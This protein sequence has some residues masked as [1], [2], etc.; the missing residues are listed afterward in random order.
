[1]AKVLTTAIQNQYNQQKIKTRFILKINNVD[2]SDYL[3]TWTL[4]TSK[5]FGSSQAT[6]VLHNNSEIFSEGGSSNIKVGDV[7]AFSEFFQEDST[8]F[9]K[10]YGMISQRSIKKT[11]SERSITLVCL[12]YISTLQYLDIDLECEGDK[13]LIE[14]ETLTPNYLPYPNDSLAHIFNFANNAIAQN[15]TPII[16]IKNKNT[17]VEDPQY[18][19]FEIMYEDGQLKL[20]YPLNALHN[21]DVICS[22]YYFYVKGLYAEDIIES[23]LTLPDGYGKYLFNEATA[24]DVI[25]NHLIDSFQ[26]VENTTTD[27]MS[28]NYTPSEITVE[29]YLVG[30]INSSAT[31][32]TV[33][34]A[35][36]L[37]DSG[38]G[39]VAGDIFTWS[40]K[41]GNILQ[42]IPPTGTYSLSNHKATS[43]VT[44]TY[45]FPRGQVWY[46]KYSN[47]QTD[48]VSGDFT[49][50]GANFVYLDKRFGRI[51]LDTAIVTDSVVTCNSNYSF[52]TLQASGIELSTMSFRSREVENRFA[53]LKK[54]KDYLAPN[55]MIL[56]RG[57]E[58]IWSMYMSQKTREDYT[59]QLET[60]L[61]YLEDEDLYTRVV[62]YGKNKNPTNLMF[63]DGISFGSTGE[64]YKS[65]ASNSDIV[66]S[67]EEGDFWVY[68]SP[69]SGIGKIL[70]ETMMPTVYLNDVAIDN[71][72]HIIAGQ[73]VAIE[74]TTK[75][76]TT[77]S[78][79]GK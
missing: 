22:K 2:Y 51:I 17:D 42:G 60:S 50:P 45:T 36:G 65:I 72:S 28:P 6:F 25:D 21:Y 49:I 32:L 35:S 56:T 55:Y 76:D 30:D 10:F 27:T 5:E 79:G 15:P 11:S 75:T 64:T 4:Q 66:I 24:Q 78:G 48:L 47:L 16:V 38:E 7:V 29:T 1:M 63:G 57:D 43:L 69:I 26:N 14:N 37:P 33:T 31:S 19:G 68:G 8:E 54:L 73:Q 9:K 74:T 20:G 71:T 58:K 41:S 23:I 77:S 44:W 13:V 12:D 34:D 46:L 40:S 61:T 59:L 39:K 52:K 3:V 62:M 53:G 67:R 70:V 18:D